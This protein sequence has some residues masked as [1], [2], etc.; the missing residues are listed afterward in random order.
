[1]S[2][3]TDEDRRDNLQRSA[4]Y[5]TT[6]RKFLKWYTGWN[7]AETTKLEHVEMA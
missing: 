5:W 7:T 2:N 1:M 6:Q 3:R 4:Q